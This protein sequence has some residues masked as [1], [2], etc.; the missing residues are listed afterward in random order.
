VAHTPGHTEGS[1]TFLAGDAAFTGDFIFITSVGRPDLAG[2]ADAWTPQLY[3]SLAQ[4]K[5]TWPAETRILPAHYSGNAERSADR[6]VWMAFGEVHAIN[7]PLRLE[8][9]AQFAAWVSARLKDAPQAYRY[10]K[11]INV[12]LMDVEPHYA[13]ELEAGK[14]ECAVG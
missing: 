5:A 7:E 3:A 14:N 12:G 2:K 6:S 13:S 8:D 9:A 1:V 4:A 11:A 10:I